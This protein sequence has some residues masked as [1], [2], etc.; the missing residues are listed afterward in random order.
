MANTDTATG[1]SG[2]GAESTTD[3]VIAGI[4]LAG[5]TVLVT[6]ASAGLGVETSRVLA[7]AGALVIMAARNIAKV[8]LAAETIRSQHP[9]AQLEFVEV[10]LADLD[11]VRRCGAQLLE[12]FSVIDILINNAGIMACPLE[13]TV[14]GFEM[15]FGT[16]HLGHF[17]LTGLLLPL[18]K[19]APIA[20][21]VNLSSGGHKYGPVD[22]ED[23]NYEKKEYNK[24][25]SYG[26]A[27]TANALFSVG[28][29]Q[30]FTA[31]GIYSN[32]VHPGAIVTE[33]GRHLSDEDI[34][35]LM[36][37][38]LG[39]GSFTYKTIPQGAATSV[40]AATSTQLEGK[41]ACYLEDCNVAEPA[42]EAAPEKGYSPYVLDQASA[43]KLWLLSEELVGEKFA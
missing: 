19:A 10:D 22:F 25:L 39:R 13:R 29:T 11:S 8:E 4:D 42:S 5:K 21:V 7:A 32:A 12:R 23:W 33:L 30:R 14:Q 37:N 35:A 9:Q 36:D 34:K 2:F 31:D 20:R 27:K 6:G 28:L 40:W 3:E 38:S 16:N 18:L 1:I 15:Q 24:W 26:Q 41:G 17:L 43:N